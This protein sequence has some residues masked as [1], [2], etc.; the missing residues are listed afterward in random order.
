MDPERPPAEPAAI[1]EAAR[2]QREQRVFALMEVGVHVEEPSTT[3]VGEDVQSAPGARIRLATLALS[4]R[5]AVHARE[6]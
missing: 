1:A 6:H 3:Q 5:S 4:A 2:R